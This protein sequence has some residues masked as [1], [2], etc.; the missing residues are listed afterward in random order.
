MES[1]KRLRIAV[2]C[3]GNDKLG[4]LSEHVF[5]I[6]LMPNEGTK[7]KVVGFATPDEVESGLKSGDIVQRLETSHTACPSCLTT[8]IGRSIEELSEM[9]DFSEI[10]SLYKKFRLSH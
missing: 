10:V 1:D 5:A 3:S 8:F 2:P 4:N 7:R 9:S 6:K